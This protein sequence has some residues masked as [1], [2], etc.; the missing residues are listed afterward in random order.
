MIHEIGLRIRVGRAA[1][2]SLF[3]LKMLH[4]FCQGYGMQLVFIGTISCS[5]MNF[6]KRSS[7]PVNRRRLNVSDVHAKV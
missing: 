5:T 1:K 7:F 4:V 6:K 3:G 2:P